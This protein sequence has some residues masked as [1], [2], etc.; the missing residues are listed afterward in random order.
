MAKVYFRILLEKL[1]CLLEVSAYQLE[2]TFH[3]HGKFWISFFMKS[4]SYDNIIDKDE[5]RKQENMQLNECSLI[6]ATLWAV[7]S[8]GQFSWVK[9]SS[10][11]KKTLSHTVESS[12]RIL[13]HVG[14]RTIAP[15]E[16]TC[17]SEGK[18]SP[19]N[20][21]P[22][23]LKSRHLTSTKKGGSSAKP[24][25]ASQSMRQQYMEVVSTKETLQVP[26]LVPGVC[27]HEG[28]TT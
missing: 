15:G 6:K 19:F 17:P 23:D 13:P 25:R 11:R 7:H 4:V 22:P 8:L 9:S 28:E 14:T 16:I 21:T 5:K 2:N 27:V 12:C 10:W 3:C 24:K 18:I 20:E 26:C 1:F